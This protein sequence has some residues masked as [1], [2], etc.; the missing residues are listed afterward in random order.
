MS[1]FLKHKEKLC[2]LK[3]LGSASL[4]KN[5][6]RRLFIFYPIIDLL[7]MQL[8][9]KLVLPLD[10]FERMPCL[11]LFVLSAGV[12]CTFQKWKWCPALHSSI[13]FLFSIFSKIFWL[14]F[15]HPW[16]K[17][18]DFGKQKVCCSEW[19]SCKLLIRPM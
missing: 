17:H 4:E 7:H 2:R 15:F 5:Y 11:A 9:Q 1:H 12:P 14:F 19:L 8:D 6:F 3:F 16:Q 18:V 13:F 10:V